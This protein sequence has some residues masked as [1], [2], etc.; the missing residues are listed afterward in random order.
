METCPYYQLVAASLSKLVR[1]YCWARAEGLVVPTLQED[2]SCRNQYRTCP[3]YREALV[4]RRVEIG[5]LL[6]HL[7]RNGDP[8]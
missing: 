3:H 7:T 1:G 6:P 2:C 8:F 4:E 5:A